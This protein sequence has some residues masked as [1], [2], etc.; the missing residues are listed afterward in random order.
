M[1]VDIQK[2]EASKDLTSIAFEFFLSF[3]PFSSPETA[4]LSIDSRRYNF[5]KRIVEF[6]V[7]KRWLGQN[8]GR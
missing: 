1:V 4:K 7:I 2:F 5:F 6:S 8:Y 3:F